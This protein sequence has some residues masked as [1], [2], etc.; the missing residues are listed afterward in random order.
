MLEIPDIF[1][2]RMI[3]AGSE[4]TV[5][6]YEVKMRVPPPPPL[7]LEHWVSRNKV[8]Y[9]CSL[10]CLRRCDARYLKITKFIDNFYD[11]T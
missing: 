6:T 5:A 11:V 10:N 9:V 8:Y 1:W 4:P 3:G 2:G 7:K